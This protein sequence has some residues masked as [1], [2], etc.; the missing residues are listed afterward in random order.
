MST[1]IGGSPAPGLTLRQ[2]FR[3]HQGPVGHVAWF[4]DGS[5]LASCS[6]DQTIRVWDVSNGDTV[7]RIEGGNQVASLAWSPDGTLL[8]T[9]RDKSVILWK[10]FSW[11]FV[12]RLEGHQSTVSCLAWSPD[13]DYLASCSSDNT[14]RLWKG[15]DAASAAT[16]KGHRGEVLGVAWSP[17]SSHL[18][19]C[20]KDGT[21]RIWNSQTHQLLR[22]IKDSDDY[23]Y[24]VGWSPTGQL[25]SGSGNNTICLWDYATGHR[26]KVLE[27]HSSSIASIAFSG[28]GL[29]LASKSSDNTVI[30]RW[31]QLTAVAT[32]AEGAPGQFPPKLSFHP[33]RPLLATPGENSII[34]IWEL[35]ETILL[36]QEIDSVNYTTARLVLVGDSGVGKTGLGWR[37]AKGEFKEHASTHGQQFWPIKQ[38]GFKRD[39]G[40]NCEAVLWDLAGQHVYRQIHSIFLE[41]V[42]AALVLFD[43]TNRQDQLKGVQFWL[44]QLK[45]K[46]QLP[47]TILVGARV[48]RGAPAMSQEELDE[49]CQ[50][51]GIR[52]GYLSTSANT[53]EGLDA[54]IARLNKLIPWDEMTATVTT[55][56]FKRIKDYVLMLKERPDRKGVLVRP[57]DLSKELAAIDPAWEFD[58]AE[59][60]TAVGHLETLGYLAVLS[61]SAGEDHILLA[62]ELL[63][64]LAAS[65]V[66]LADRHPRELGA[67]NETELL[68]GTYEFD[69][70]KGLSADESQ[71]LLNAAILRFLQHNICFRETLSDDIL[72][73]AT[74]LIFP[75]LIKQRRPLEDNL[76]SVEDV[77]YV[78]RGQV[79]NL[80]ASLVVLLGYTLSITR[81]DQWQNQAQYEMGE[82][83][84][85]GFRLIEDRDGEI[86]IG[87]YYGSRMAA[88]ARTQF[89]EL[90]EQFLYRREVEVRRLQ[91]VVCPKEHRQQRA[92][93]IKRVR[94][95]KRFVHCE[96]CGTKTELP[97]FEKPQTIGIN[98]SPW[99]QRQEAI[100][101]LRTKY[102]EYLTNIKSYRSVWTTPRAYVSH[103]LDEAAWAEKLID[104]LWDAGVHVVEEPARVE[105]GDFVILLDTATYQKAFNAG[106]LDADRPLVEL[107]F[108]KSRLISLAL[109]GQTASHSFR[110]CRLGSFCDE[111]HYAVSLFDL[112]L[113]LYAIRLE[114]PAF[115]PLR[116][117]LHTQWESTLGGMTAKS[118]SDQQSKAVKV[119]ISYDHDDE[120]FKDEFLAVIKPLES[121]GVLE[122]WHDR[123]IEEGD[124]WRPAI[125]TAI[126]ECDITLLFTSTSFLN[127]KFIKDE[128]L[129]LFERRKRQG[130]QV[131]PIIIKPCMWQ[132]VQFLADLQVL[133]KNAVPVSLA[134]G[135]QRDA[136]WMEIAEA[137]ERQARNLS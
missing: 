54:L 117:S 59:M 19:S 15:A 45:G 62:P 40:T 81:V 30:W 89:Q 13:G 78:V 94:E 39:D 26:S 10:A 102:E 125:E 51:Y 70:L 75:N 85:C 101:L 36:G 129:P 3:G 136:V 8:A 37:L 4:P 56:A 106:L 16:L 1:E 88:E 31:D 122:I 14:I 134:E 69:E 72:S 68:K 112:V 132:R 17:D 52:G 110:N 29:W 22:S 137:I 118:A 87:L 35:D 121:N 12:R 120:P 73:G 109:S 5:Y 107:R 90:F 41:K 24:T 86:E 58:E 123:K 103:H 96:E 47:P 53:G 28:N 98:A 44:E 135:N 25:V 11:E 49:F 34:R 27:A 76:P 18:A 71:I 32:L 65:V 50:Q 119:F 82:E 66:L 21:I 100:A 128:E 80:Y 133:P 91:P 48:D 20:S 64:T 2:V 74:L 111:T 127:S 84:T 46:G 99:L 115:R 67:V 124:E 23:V 79:E 33:S 114:D 108:G 9:S 83:Q 61:S 93:I 97:D 57:E 7:H 63:A 104:Y 6:N 60:M 131:I 42:T 105:D 113:N 130:L 77:T 95:G 38:L 116:E 43:P 126:N 55:V 92:T